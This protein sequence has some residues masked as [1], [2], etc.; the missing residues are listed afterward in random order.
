MLNHWAAVTD[1]LDR[2]ADGALVELGEAGWVARADLDGD[3]PEVALRRPSAGE[4]GEVGDRGLAVE[5]RHAERL[6][7]LL[8]ADQRADVDGLVRRRRVVARGSGF[9]DQ[10]VG[11]GVIIVVATA[12]SSAIA[13]DT[14]TA[15]EADRPLRR[16]IAP[17]DRQRAAGSVAR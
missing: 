6:G 8:L 14:N 1:A 5:Q 13:T 2:L 15:P 17:P 12:R 10:V 9:D 4:L 11:G 3:L 7:C 16:P